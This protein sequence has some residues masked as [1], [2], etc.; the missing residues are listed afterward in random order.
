[1]TTLTGIGPLTRFTLRRDRLRLALWVVALAGTVVAS[2]VSLLSVYPDQASIDTY[3][4]VFGDNPALVAFA[5]PGYGFDDPNIGV[6]LVNETQV[7][8]AIGMAMMSIF[9]VN[10][11][12][13]AEE[14]SERAELVRSNVVGRHAPTAAAL[15]VVGAANLVVGALCAIGFVAAGYPTTGSIALAGSLAAVGLLFAGLT[16]VVAQV[17][18]SG[19]ATLGLAVA[20]LAVAFVVRAVGDIGKSWVS[21]ASPIGWAQAVRAF[22]D[23]RWWTLGL[24]VVVALALVVLAFWLSTRRD[25]GAGLV[26]ARQG[27]DA[28]PSWLTRPL[29]L[30]FR[31]QRGALLA[32]VVGVFV[33]GVVYGS[34]G[35]DIDRMIE[36]NPQIADFLA[37]LEGVSL[38]KS[39]FATVMTMMALMATGFAISSALRLRS[40]ESAGRAEPVLATPTSRWRWA[41]SHLLIAIAGT[42]VVM[43][44]AGLGA[45]L[46]YGAVV[47]EPGQVGELLEA[48]LVTVPGIL[49][50]VGVTVALF[51]LAPRATPVVWGVLAMAVVVGVL[52]GALQL[53]RW[54]RQLSPLEH[55]PKLPAESV[56]ALPLVVLTLLAAGLIV[57]GLWGFRRRDLAV[58]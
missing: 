51:G 30:A 49:V 7:F 54:T 26:A 24:C 1:M 18:S 45:G 34:V 39:Y 47:G 2:A 8:G 27:R 3:V 16:A 36:E 33:I 44:A 6:V 13:R 52:G 4:V 50:L 15:V 42:V 43:A 28:A 56:A 32:W 41:S 25:L 29:G 12:T 55:V 14:E 20:L 58:S 22:A 11:H 19:R 17:A 23:E 21:W 9:L 48:A 10:R 35:D 38:S 57:L 37:Q 53:P 40:E 5:G 31:L 46:S